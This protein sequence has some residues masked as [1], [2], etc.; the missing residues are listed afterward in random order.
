MGRHVA[1]LRGINVGANRKVPMARLRALC[2]GL[3][4]AEVETYIQSGNLVFAASGSA[5]A[6]EAALE[7]AIAGE[8][9]FD[10]AVIVRSA[11]DWPG[12][13]AGNPFPEAARD[14][15]NRLML[16]LSKRPPAA[17]AEEAIAAKAAAGEQVRRV[18]DALWI[19]YPQGAGTTKISPNLL[20]RA[21]GSP[22]TAR[23]WRTVLTIGE[24]LER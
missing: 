1:L 10:I 22:V 24:M 8:F 3:G 17:G 14:A 21:A 15:P 13:V 5:A 16:H 11:G 7:Q 9:G 18:G 2:A 12:Y 19:H 20:D 4:W 6:L 23:N